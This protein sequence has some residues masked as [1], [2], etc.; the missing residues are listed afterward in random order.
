ME[1]KKLLTVAGN[2][3]GN[4]ILGGGEIMR[5]LL[6]LNLLLLYLVSYT[7]YVLNLLSFPY[8]KNRYNIADVL[9]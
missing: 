5:I 7:F 3:F 9:I 8:E 4:S 1:Y 2:N 6:H